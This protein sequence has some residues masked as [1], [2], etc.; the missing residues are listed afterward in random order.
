VRPETEN[1][2]AA[3]QHRF[4]FAQLGEHRFH[5]RVEQGLY[6]SQDVRRRAPGPLPRWHSGSLS[7]RP[8]RVISSFF[9][10]GAVRAA[11]M[12]LMLIWHG[13]KEERIGAGADASQV[14]PPDSVWM[15]LCLIKLPFTSNTS[16]LPEVLLRSADLAY[17][18]ANPLWVASPPGLAEFCVGEVQEKIA[19]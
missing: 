5:D 18:P 10:G 3:A 2:A 19:A 6:L 14:S 8:H 12:L 17:R 15:S 9:E 13:S 1:S 4:V 11:G 7:P 16:V